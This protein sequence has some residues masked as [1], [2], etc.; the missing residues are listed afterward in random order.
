MYHIYCNVRRLQIS[1]IDLG[2][3]TPEG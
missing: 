2:L 1:R 3:V